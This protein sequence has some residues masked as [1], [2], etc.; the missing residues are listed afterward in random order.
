MDSL[1]SKE[2]AAKARALFLQGYSC[3]QAVFAAFAGPMGLSLEQA[4]KL[5]AGLGGGIGG[6]RLTCG[7]V[8]AMAM[9]LGALQG[10]GGPEDREGKQRLYQRIQALHSRFVETYQASDC[11]TLLKNAGVEPKALPA[12][13][14]PAYY[15]TRPCVQYVESCAELVAQALLQ[16]K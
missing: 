10:Y 11:F 7:A 4:L 14:T 3:A 13:R 12:E 5:S 8:S 6:L 15:Q 16:E 1:R 9:V 2:Q